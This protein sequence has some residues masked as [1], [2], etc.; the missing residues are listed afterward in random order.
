MREMKGGVD[1]APPAPGGA[2][3]GQFFLEEALLCDRVAD[4]LN[5]GLLAGD[6]LVV[7][8]TPAH[9]Q[10]LTAALT[11]AARPT[12][13]AAGFDIADLCARR[14]L[15]LLDADEI[16]AKFMVGDSP[17][18]DRFQHVMEEVLDRGDRSRQR[19]RLRVYGEMID[20]LWKSGNPQAAIRLEE[21]WND[22]VRGH[23][24]ELLHA[25]AM[26]SFYMS[27]VDAQGMAT[28]PPA[29]EG[30]E[31]TTR[32]LVAEIS[33]RKKLEVELRRFIRDRRRTEHEA[34]AAAARMAELQ[35]ATARM[36]TALDVVAVGEILLSVS[37]RVL[38]ARAGVFYLPDEQGRYCLQATHGGLAETVK[39]WSV[40]PLDS[41]LPLAT[42]ITSAAPVW[43]E[44]YPVRLPVQRKGNATPPQAGPTGDHKGGDLQAVVAMPILQG[45]RVLG[46]FGLSFGAARKFEEGE[47]RWLESF[48][49]QCGLAI[50]RARLY[51]GEQRAR[52]EAE[53]LFRI[54]ASLN[55]TQLDRAAIVQCVTDQATAMVGAEV[56]AF[57][58]N[59]PNQEGGAELLYT[60]SGA[61][62]EA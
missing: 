42:A 51:E 28:K 46:G 37:E 40:L 18:W 52:A 39:E 49:S 55:S 17:D 35:N 27:Q 26:G 16:L 20:V 59:A 1:A 25:Y 60:M 58:Y 10:T 50:E 61:P 22:L 48:A 7:I 19:Q 47:R 32:E 44:E 54:A 41:S 33:A 15:I 24:L 2:H 29:D 30:L 3:A 4:F 13:R 23:S 11:T 21:M 8:A 12:D 34:R 56:G 9:R 36:A 38:G 31:R 5:Q 45:T 57:F 43:I 14:Q 62:A 53:T 6:A